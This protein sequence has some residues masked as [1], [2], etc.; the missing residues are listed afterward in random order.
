MNDCKQCPLPVCNNRT[1]HREVKLGY[2]AKPGEPFRDDEY[3]RPVPIFP[4]CFD[5]DVSA[6]FQLVWEDR[7]F[8]DGPVPQPLDRATG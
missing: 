4:D 2:L 1:A 6:L 5:C 3:T 7:A 8:L